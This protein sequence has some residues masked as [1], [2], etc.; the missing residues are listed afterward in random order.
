MTLDPQTADLAAKALLEAEWTEHGARTRTCGGCHHAW[1]FPA[2]GHRQ[3]CCVDAALTSLGYPT[4]ESRN[5]ARGDLW[6][7]DYV[8]AKT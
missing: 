5:A 4:E 6:R 2:E 1:A 7:A 8:K 3:G